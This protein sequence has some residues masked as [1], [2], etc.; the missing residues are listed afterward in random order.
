MSHQTTPVTFMVLAAIAVSAIGFGGT[1]NGAEPSTAF[2]PGFPIPVFDGGKSNSLAQWVRPGI[3]FRNGRGPAGDY[4]FYEVPNERVTAVGTP[5]KRANWRAG[6]LWWLPNPQPA[7]LRE[8][9]WS[10]WQGV[11][12]GIHQPQAEVE[13]LKR[14]FCIAFIT[15]DPGK[16]WDAWYAYLT[17]KHG[18]SKK[19]AF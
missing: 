8:I 2:G 10:H 18:L 5:A 15:P 19:P 11:A 9:P 7:A 14:G 4:T 17:E 1:M 16:Q 6:A 12:T 13:L 3:R